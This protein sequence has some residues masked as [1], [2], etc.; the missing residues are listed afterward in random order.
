MSEFFLNRVFPVGSTGLKLM[1][2]G[3]APV[4]EKGP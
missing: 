1:I 3:A 2:E 4:P